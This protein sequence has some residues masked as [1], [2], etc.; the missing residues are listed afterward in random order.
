MIFLVLIGLLVAVPLALVLAATP[1]VKYIVAIIA[2][3]SLLIAVPWLAIPVGLVVLVPGFLL[4]RS[5]KREKAGKVM[6][7]P[8]GRGAER[9][10]AQRPLAENGN[11]AADIELHC[12]WCGATVG[13]HDRFCRVC[14]RRLHRS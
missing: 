7:A 8:N 12:P 9:T 11:R 10:S 5:H 14:G 3:V 2:F 6:K 1:T 4:W 13:L